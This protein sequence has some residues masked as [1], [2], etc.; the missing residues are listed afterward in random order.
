MWWQFFSVRVGHFFQLSLK[1]ANKSTTL[2]TM[3]ANTV[4]CVQAQMPSL[5]Q[6]QIFNGKWNCVIRMTLVPLFIN[7][8]V[9]MLGPVIN[10]SLPCKHFLRKIQKVLF[11]SIWP[12]SVSTAKSY[13]PLYEGAETSLA[14]KES[15]GL[16]PWPQLW[17]H[18]QRVWWKSLSYLKE[19]LGVNNSIALL[20]KVPE[21][22]WYSNSEPA[23]N[24]E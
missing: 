1:L 12:T 8:T 16:A 4:D 2:K 10:N 15:W 22:C 11:L 9:K 13:M 7:P 19:K 20:F 21:H 5:S 23:A 18:T 24:S 17:V 3:C 14:L 6:K